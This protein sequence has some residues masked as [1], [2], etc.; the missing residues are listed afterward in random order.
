MIII[1][2][3]DGHGINTPGKRS[4]S[5]YKENEFNHYTKEF[6]EDEINRQP[7][8]KFVDV[9]PTRADDSL[10]TRVNRANNAN[11][12]VFVSIHYNAFTG[13]WQDN[14]KGIETYYHGGS[15]K[16]KKLATLVH[17]ELIRGT[18][19][20]NRGVKSDK[21]IY[22]S[23]FYV[24]RYTKM[25]AIL[26]ECGFMDNPHDFELMKSSNYRKE[27]AIEICRGIC[28]YFNKTYIPAKV[29]SNILYSD[30]PYT[31]WMYDNKLIFGKT[32]KKTSKPSFEQ[33]GIILKRFQ[34][35]F[36]K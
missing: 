29:K 12:D 10:Q 28:K 6:L 8:F 27:C 36:C 1:G 21:S 3:G 35:K 14:A 18:K 9:S 16:G 26:V 17:S 31:R 11:A 34:D 32:Y 15:T 2:A 19:M 20:T 5:G 23:G 7:D 25:P 22:G 4:P 24:L 13:K 30:M 33:L